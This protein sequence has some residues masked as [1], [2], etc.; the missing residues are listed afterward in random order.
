MEDKRRDSLWIDEMGH[1]YPEL[2][3]TCQLLSE[4]FT[5]I[6]KKQFEARTALEVSKVELEQF[7]K[8]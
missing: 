3:K 6:K 7:D 2:V 8:D 1:Q 4:V 5:T